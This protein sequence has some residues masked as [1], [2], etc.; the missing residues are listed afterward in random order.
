MQ[1]YIWFRALTGSR[2]YGLNND[3]SDYDWRGFYAPMTS[4]FFNMSALPEQIEI[5]QKDE[6]YWE[7]SKFVRLL[8]ANNPN[9]L[10]TLWTHH[11]EILKHIDGRDVLI[12]N[13]VNYLLDNKSKILSRKLFK[14]YRGYAMSQLDRG[15]KYLL[16]PDTQQQGF[17]HLMHLCRLLVSCNHAIRYNELLVN[18]S[19]YRGSLLAVRSGKL[20]YGQIEKWHSDLNDEF[21]SLEKSSTLPEEPD[22]QLLNDF[23]RQIRYALL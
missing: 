11:Y 21:I 17:K 7:A 5:P 10:E 14:T 18:V 22:S 15:K 13:A 12:E 2:A 23:L 1:N 3:D 9:V 20:S 4:N 6:V 16:S 19:D 8:H